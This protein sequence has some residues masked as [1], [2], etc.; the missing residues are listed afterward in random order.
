MKMDAAAKYLPYMYERREVEKITLWQM[1]LYGRRGIL[2]LLDKSPVCWN[3]VMWIYKATL[4]AYILFA[5]TFYIIHETARA[6]LE[7]F[8]ELRGIGRDLGFACRRC[9]YELYKRFLT[10][11]DDVQY[12]PMREVLWVKLMEIETVAAGGTREDANVK[13]RRSRGSGTA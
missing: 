9:D 1:L 13:S 12:R 7:V 6:V 8:A 2:R 4:P 11:P 3:C 5:I 10:S